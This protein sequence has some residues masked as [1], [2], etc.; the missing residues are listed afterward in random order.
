MNVSWFAIFQTVEE[1]VSTNPQQYRH[2]PSLHPV[3]S[4]TVGPV[5]C[6]AN[7]LVSRGPRRAFLNTMPTATQPILEMDAAYPEFKL[8][9]L[10]RARYRKGAVLP[11]ERHCPALRRECPPGRPQKS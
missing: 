1:S 10:R 7:I 9:P 5:V 11:H 2:C 3:G 4:G 6:L 8:G